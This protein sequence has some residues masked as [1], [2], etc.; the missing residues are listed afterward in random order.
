MAS[1]V[2]IVSAKEIASL[3]IRID[4]SRAVAF[5]DS[6]SLTATKARSRLVMMS[7]PTRCSLAFSPS[8]VSLSNM[9]G[10]LTNALRIPG[11][12]SAI[13]SATKLFSVLICLP[14]GLTIKFLKATLLVIFAASS[15]PVNFSTA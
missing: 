6:S 2:G 14:C 12:F 13:A 1:P 7:R 10:T 5:L 15:S 11:S 4:A 8:Q 9:S 3:L